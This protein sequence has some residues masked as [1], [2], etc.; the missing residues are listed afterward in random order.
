M[1]K[2]QAL[3]NI[4]N[5]ST[6]GN[7]KVEEITGTTFL[8]PVCTRWCSEY[9][10]VERVVKIG[11]TEA[12]KCA[13]ELKIQPLSE[14]D[15]LFLNSFLK[16]MKIIVRAMDFLQQEKDC[17]MG[18]L[19][20]TIMGIQKKLEENTDKAMEPLKKALLAGLVARFSSVLH[21]QDYIIATMLL[22]QFRLSCVSEERRLECRQLV[23]DYVQRVQREVG[24]LHVSTFRSTESSQQES[25]H[26]NND[27]DLF[28][29]LQ[30]SYSSDQ[31]CDSDTLSNEVSSYFI[32]RDTS[33]KCLTQYAAISTAFMK[34]NATLPCS[35]AV[36]RLFS[37]ASQILTKRRCRLSDDNF[38]KLVFL[39][40]F[41]KSNT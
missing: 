28:S 19:I 25:A 15:F 3:S 10:A 30:S 29:F 35:A 38:D 23:H 40:Y 20:P 18:H 11:I 16:L 6:S 37:V 33:V 27:D 12:E 32:S 22:P 21:D 14:A 24:D 39:R 7:D 41:L 17:Y 13:K 34:C 8:K 36:E 9:Y 26:H 1:G 4:V 2:V 5:R 31:A